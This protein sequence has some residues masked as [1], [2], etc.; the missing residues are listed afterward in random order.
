MPNDGEECHEGGRTGGLHT[1]PST[2]D[3][4]FAKCFSAFWTWGTFGGP[5]PFRSACE[6]TPHPSPPSRNSRDLT[7]TAPA[8]KLFWFCD[9]VTGV[10]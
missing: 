4:W 10:T 1:L 6:T 3:D 7:A 5:T 8:P 2:T 9:N